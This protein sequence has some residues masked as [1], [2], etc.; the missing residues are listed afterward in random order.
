MRTT[1]TIAD[2]KANALKYKLPEE[3]SLMN[4]ATAIARAITP[5]KTIGTPA[6]KPQIPIALN[7]VAGGVTLA[8]KFD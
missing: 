2:A 4:T 6:I 3:P 5:K 8:A 1:P 7:R